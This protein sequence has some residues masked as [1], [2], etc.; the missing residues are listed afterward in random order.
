MNRKDFL[1]LLNEKILILDG[2]YGTEFIKK[3]YSKIPAEVLNIKYPDVVCDLQKEYVKAGSDILLTNTFSANRKKLRELGFEKEFEQINAQAVQIAR[4]ASNQTT[5]VFGDLSSLGEFPKP[6]GKLDMDEAIEEYYQ[7]AKV[8]FE[9][10][11]DGFIVETMTD[12]K[13]LKAAVYGIRKVIDN[14]PLIAHMTFESNGRSVTGTSV[15]IF[16]NVFND[17]DVDVLGI[18]C[19]L[20]PE[21]LLRVFERLSLSTN[22]FLS[23]EPNAG[24]PIFDGEKLEYKMSPEIFGVYTEDYLDAGVNIIGGCC[25]TTPE[26]IRVIR[27]MVQRR[28]RNISKE[29]PV[30]YSSRTI[31]K[32]FH[33]F[34]VIGERINPAGSKKFQSEIEAFNFERVIKRSNSQ[35]KAQADAIDLNLG[36]EKILTKEHFIQS[37]NELDKHSSLP[38]SFDIQNFDY[39]EK[40]L[41]EYP[42]RAI[43]NSS[44]LS[45]KDLERKLELIKK[46]G[47]LLI[48]LAL[49][50][51]ILE[52]AEERFQ[53]VVKKWPLIK[54]KGFEKNRFIIDPLVLSLGAN[55]DPKI[56]LEL[57]KLLSQDGFNT[58]LGLSNLSFGLPDRKFINAAF[59]SR[60]RYN[61][62]TSAIMNPEDEFLMNTLKGNLLLDKNIVATNKIEDQDELTEKIL[63]GEKEEVKK[64]IEREL[65]SKSPLEVSQKILGESMENIG[66]LYAKGSIYLPELLLAAET[67]KPIFDYLNQMIPATESN[68]KAKVVLATVEGDIHDI[69]KNIVGSVLKSGN[70]EVIDLG[71]DVETQIIIDAVKKHSPEILGLSAMMT[72]TVGKIEEVVKELKKYGINVKVITGGASMNKKL[73]ENFGCD[74]Y[75]KDASEGLKICKNWVSEL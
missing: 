9:S 1:Q 22:K 12:I 49:E 56:T 25:G 31:L 17:L 52:T 39:L 68:K 13:E 44:K 50:K 71:K 46:Y 34:T 43:I 64:I 32:T 19:T 4:R 30:M 37:V 51:E 63:Q 38:I 41:K 72:T 47:G 55:N 40:A 11:V 74:A 23:V 58:T 6:M 48:L 33:P 67:V 45:K 59:L 21:E 57:I 65:E 15:E 3:G 20:G 2:G 69:G 14:L 66:E 61:G 54:D 36:I 24:K 62:L 73:A 29:I 16:A 70:F 42:G 8:L 75:A 5:L 26:H 18:N 35:K 7:Q 60:A 28:P 53:L 10:G 27:K